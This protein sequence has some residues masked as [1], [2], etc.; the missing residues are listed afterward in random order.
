LK[1]A[2]FHA[3]DLNRFIP[4]SSHYLAR[5]HW[6][7]PGLDLLTLPYYSIPYASPYL[8]SSTTL[9]SGIVYEL[10]ILGLTS[11]GTL[12]FQTTN[13]QR[14]L[15]SRT[16]PGLPLPLSLTLSSSTSNSSSAR[17]RSWSQE[18]RTSKLF[19]FLP[20]VAETVR[21]EDSSRS[22]SLESII[23]GSD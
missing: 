21:L 1:R 15:P 23:H 5:S 11:V 14:N 3:D 17:P 2:V 8:V 4:R 13:R 6:T 18:R 7:R 9:I 16:S 22:Y 10:L 19:R 12:G 20:I